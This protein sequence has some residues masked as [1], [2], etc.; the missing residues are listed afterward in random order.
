LSR[1]IECC[2]GTVVAV[3]KVESC[4]SAWVVRQRLSGP[5]E[6]KLRGGESQMVS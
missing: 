4:S 2:Q 1:A 3:A 6:W 5:L